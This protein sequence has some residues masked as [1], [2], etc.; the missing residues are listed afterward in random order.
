MSGAIDTFECS[1]TLHCGR[2]V[3]FK[4]TPAMN[5]FMRLHTKKCKACFGIKY[6]HQLIITQH[7]WGRRNQVEQSLREANEAHELHRALSSLH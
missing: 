4:S 5:T 3:T 2:K 1:V 7:D 6:H